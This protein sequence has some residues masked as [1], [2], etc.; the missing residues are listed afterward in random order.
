MPLRKITRLVHVLNE[1]IHTFEGR[2][3]YP[4]VTE[5]LIKLAECIADFEGETE[6]IWSIGENLECLDDLL[7]GAYWHYVH[8]SGGQG[9][10]EYLAQR[11]IGQVVS[12]GMG[13]EA[14]FIADSMSYSN[15][16]NMASQYHPGNALPD[17]TPTQT[18]LFD[19][20]V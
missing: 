11:V 13:S 8:H 3:S 14:D 7:T 5:G 2:L 12:P 15:L 16:N 19:T 10:Q 4:R 20:E 17:V 9:S 1:N 6:N 18:N